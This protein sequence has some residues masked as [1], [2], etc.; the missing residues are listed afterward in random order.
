MTMKLPVKAKEIMAAT[1]WSKE[2]M[3]K[4]RT[5]NWIKWKKDEK[6]GFVYDLTSVPQQLVKDKTSN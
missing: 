2:D 1:G 4:A 5:Y 3:R 6:L